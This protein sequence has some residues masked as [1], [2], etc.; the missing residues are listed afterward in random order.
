LGQETVAVETVSKPLWSFGE[1]AQ[2]RG[3]SV[4][5]SEQR[6]PLL[7]PQEVKELPADEALI[8]YEGLRPIRCRRIRYY[9]DRGLRARL[10]PPPAR[11][12]ALTLLRHDLPRHGTSA[13]AHPRGADAKSAALLERAVT[14][15]DI[16]TMDDWTPET[17]VHDVPAD[18]FA[19]ARSDAPLADM[20][21]QDTVQRFLRSFD[22]PVRA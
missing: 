14:A 10:R 18:L 8:F 7:L 5:V 13:P 9:Q 11:P 12:A 3:R 15:R 21:L 16:E 1:H 19:A 4:S 22:S 6:R 17:V 20:D 2:R